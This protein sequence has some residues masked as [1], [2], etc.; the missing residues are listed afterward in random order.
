MHVRGKAVQV[1]GFLG[2]RGRE[3]RVGEKN[4]GARTGPQKG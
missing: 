3:V 1:K 2:E 4:E